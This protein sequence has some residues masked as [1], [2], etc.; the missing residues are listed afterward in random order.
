MKTTITKEKAKEINGAV[1]ERL[2]DLTQKQLLYDIGLMLLQINT[3]LEH[4]KNILKPQNHGNKTV[5]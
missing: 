5:D 4:I 2:K 3:N 1:N